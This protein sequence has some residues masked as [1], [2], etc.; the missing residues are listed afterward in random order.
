GTEIRFDLGAPGIEGNVGGDLE[1]EPVILGLADLNAGAAGSLLHFL[2][3]LFHAVG[4][5]IA[6]DGTGHTTDH[7]TLAG[8]VA[9]TAVRGTADD[10]AEARTNAS[11]GG[12]AALSRGHIGATGGRHGQDGDAN[13]GPRGGQTEA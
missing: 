2:A 6:D 7:G 1:L 4:P 11:A 9:A 12:S 5:D 3:L 8:T 13:Q 10:G